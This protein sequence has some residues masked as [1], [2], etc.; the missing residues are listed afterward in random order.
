MS[1]LNIF[2]QESTKSSRYC[3]K[4]KEIKSIQIGEDQTKLSLFVDS[5]IV[6]RENPKESTK[7]AIKTNR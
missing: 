3:I 2:I 5:M 4:K 1:A 6:C 7:R